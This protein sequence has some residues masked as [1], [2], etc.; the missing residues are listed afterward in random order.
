MPCLHWLITNCWLSNRTVV[1]SIVRLFFRLEHRSWAADAGPFIRIKRDRTEWPDGSNLVSRSCPPVIHR[2]R[3][4]NRSSF[5]RGHDWSHNGPRRRQRRGQEMTECMIRW[6]SRSVIEAVT[7]RWACVS[8]SRASR[9]CATAILLR[10]ARHP[11]R[12]RDRD[13][14]RG[15][16]GRRLEQ[17]ISSQG[18]HVTDLLCE[19]AY[20]VANRWPQPSVV[21]CP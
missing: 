14:Q 3:Q 18:V 15:N 17:L 12:Q 5:K 19:C 13:R 20:E 1:I 2:L 16:S 6:R 7:S 8:R 11:I 21:F 4:P 9:A 10:A